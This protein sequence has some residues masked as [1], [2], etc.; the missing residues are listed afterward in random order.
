MKQDTYDVA[1]YG[2]GYMGYAA[3]RALAAEGQSVLLADASGDLLWEST[4]ALV[5]ERAG[6]AVWEAWLEDL[7]ARGGTSDR[8]FET[9]LAE[10]RAADELARLQTLDVLLYAAPVAARMVGPALGAVTF[11]TKSGALAVRAR[12]WIDASEDGVLARLAGNAGSA[13]AATFWRSVVLF[14]TAWERAADGLGVFLAK[15]PGARWHESV[16][17]EERRLSWPAEAGKDLGTELLGHLRLLREVC[18]EVPI[19]VT[20]TSMRDYPVYADAAPEQ[21]AGVT[22]LLVLSPGPGAGALPGDRFRL[23]HRAAGEV[24]TLPKAGEIDSTASLPEPAEEVT[25]EVLV[26]GAGTAGA[27]AALAAAR[28]GAEVLVLEAGYSVG[29]VGTV[30]AINGYFHGASG[31]IHEEVDRLTAE[32]TPL[33][34]GRGPRNTMWHHEAKKLALG[35]LLRQSGVGFRPQTILCGVERTASGRVQAVL[36]AREGKLV[37]YVARAFVDSTGDGDLCALAGA[38]FAMGRQGDGRSLAFSQPSFY[39]IR[40]E[41][42]FQLHSWNYDAG[43]TDPT[44]PVELSRARLRGIAL[45]LK[46]EWTAEKRP[47]AI[48]PLLGLRQSRQIRTDAALSLTDLV[49]HR[50]FADAIGLTSA[51]ADTHSVDFEFESDDALFHFWVCRGFRH[52]LSAELPYRMLLPEGLENVWVAC[53][54]AGV[55]V[56]AS[57]CVRMQK[58]MQRLGEAA[59]YA[60]AQA[61]EAGAES[62]GIDLARLQADLSATGAK[63]ELAG[64]DASDPLELLAAGRGGVHLWAIYRQPGQYREALAGLLGEGG[65]ASFYAA[66]VLAM[67]GDARAEE[68]LLEAVRRREIGPEPEAGSSGAFGQVIDVPLW[69]LAVA[70]LRVCGTEKTLPALRELLAEPCV[71]NVRTTIA[72]TLERIVQRLG[73]SVEA[74]EVLARLEEIGVGDAFLPP[75]RSLWKTLQNEEQMVLR[76]QWAADTRLDHAWQLEAVLGR[77]REG[78][79]AVPGR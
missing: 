65:L 42:G 43:W 17:P 4:R 70:L 58:D 68:R 22:N 32:L 60:A 44:D 73:D 24:E 74:R 48:A 1:V 67:W 64:N 41:E 61:L 6:G 2:T 8:Y 39:L 40:G 31:G 63:R 79:S 3:A 49:E 35:T 56:E 25:C 20:H 27:V 71:F 37:R 78:L 46:D 10:I 15:Q 12:R 51:V 14:S 26:A 5:N 50:G 52:P 62:R 28:K 13:R 45:Y 23:G 9:A 69:L 34:T 30:G 66:A 36:A 59:G 7:E 75:S 29:G 18:P 47:V 76:N 19:L 57:Y 16:R 55:T 72:L 53:R 21:D 38:G 11:A 33:L 77:V 54:A